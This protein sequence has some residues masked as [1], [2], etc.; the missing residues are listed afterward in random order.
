[1][2]FEKL[3]KYITANKIK[4][5]FISPHLDDAALS[6]G[7]LINYLSD[8]TSVS[9]VS[10]FTAVSSHPYTLSARAYLRQCKNPDAKKLFDQRKEEDRKIFNLRG[11]KTIHLDFIDAQWRKKDRLNFLERIVSRI[12]P[13]ISH[14]YPIYR[15]H[16]VSGVISKLDK[17][18]IDEIK[19]ALSQIINSDQKSIVFCP[20]G[21]GKHVDHIIT[22]ECCL[23]IFDHNLGL[24]SDFP[25]N[26]K[27]V[28]VL[29]DKEKYDEINYSFDKQKKKDLIRAYETQYDAMFPG[30]SINIEDERFYIKKDV[31]NKF[32]D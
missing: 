31:S 11:V 4:V 27:S 20:L 17:K 2:K 24:W 12:I 13:E 30:D 25:Y 21:I 16:V 3:A 15:W 26:K 6:C 22:R 9:V 32:R 28:L 19:E 1:M 29:P 10:V 5:Y 14:I 7:G 23:E 18:M 8:K